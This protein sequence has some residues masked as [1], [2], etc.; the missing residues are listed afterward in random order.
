VAKRLTQK[1][2]VKTKPIEN[3]TF[4]QSVSQRKQRIWNG[5][6]AMK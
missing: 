2:E 3:M 5:T 4:S 1:P 6:Y